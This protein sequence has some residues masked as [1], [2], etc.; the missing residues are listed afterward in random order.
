MRLIFLLCFTIILPSNKNDECYRLLYEEFYENGSLKEELW[1]Y[2]KVYQHCEISRHSICFNQVVFYDDE[3]QNYSLFFANRY[4]FNGN[5]NRKLE[6]VEGSEDTLVVY[7]H[8]DIIGNLIGQEFF[9]HNYQKDEYFKRYGIW[10][11]S[12]NGVIETVFVD[13]LNEHN[14]SPIFFPDYF[15][16]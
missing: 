2:Y 12:T 3:G 16:Y 6:F 9:C 7:N 15:D 14:N 13:T 10:W 4:Y 1:V 8:Y 11:K 5:I